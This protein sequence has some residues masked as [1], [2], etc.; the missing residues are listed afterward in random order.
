MKEPI[1]RMRRVI[2]AAVKYVT[3]HV[4]NWIPS[5][6]FR[7]AWYTHV[8]GWSIAPDATILMGQYIQMP[9]LRASGW[10]VSIG[11]RSVINRGCLLYTTGGL[12]IGDNVSISGRG[13]AHHW[14]ARYE[15]SQFRRLLPTHHH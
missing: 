12:V 10:L 1:M 5:H 6:T 15:Q 14:R 13:V 11:T 3:N 8:L 2:K 4:V 7:H 9:G